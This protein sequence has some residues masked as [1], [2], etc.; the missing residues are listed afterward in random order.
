MPGHGFGELHRRPFH[1]TAR[2]PLRATKETVHSPVVREGIHEVADLCSGSVEA[3]GAQLAADSRVI[4]PQKE[5][6]IEQQGVRSL[7]LEGGTLAYVL[8]DVANPYELYAAG[9]DASGASQ[10]SDHNARW[11][12]DRQLSFPE[13]RYCTAASRSWSGPWNT[14]GIR[15]RATSCRA[16]GIPGS[17]WTVSCGFWSSWIA[18]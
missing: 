5:E 11:L 17:A 6:G 9:P 18:T 3:V 10:L 14:C 4:H 2:L 8:T 7:D 13:P 16:P 12:E 15:T 1:A